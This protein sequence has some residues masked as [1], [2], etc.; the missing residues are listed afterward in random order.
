MAK[1]PTARQAKFL[2][3]YL[4]NGGNGAD[5]HK[6]AYNTSMPPQRCAQE[7]HKFLKNPKIAP[8]VAKARQRAE[9][10]IGR[11]IETCAVSR[12]RNVAELA[13]LAYANIADYTR[14]DG[15]DRI[16]DLSA[17]TRDQLA[18]VQEIIVEDLTDGRR[19]VRIKLHDK[20]A[21][22]AEL[23]HMN[24]WVLERSEVGKPG[25]FE[26]LS[27]EELDAR[28]TEKLRERG[29]TDEQI[30]RFLDHTALPQAPRVLDPSTRRCFWGTKN[31]PPRCAS[32]DGASEKDA[33]H[34]AV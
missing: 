6:T 30:K 8:I 11:A 29:M 33:V 20:K 4:S 34:T 9:D 10:A 13:R 15:S 28:L 25:D 22:I 2:E 17:A 14:L 27:D 16:T 12:Q 31:C 23:N 1:K 21:A 26:H 19:R 3:T 5:A 18:A 32:Y 24:G 7:G